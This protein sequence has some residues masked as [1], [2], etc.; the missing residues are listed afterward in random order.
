MRRK[1][2]ISLSILSVGVALLVAA[3]GVG[4]AA[5]S[6]SSLR[7]GTL[8]INQ[9]AGTFDTLDPQLAYVTNDWQV[10]NATQLLLLNYPDRAGQ[11]GERLVPEA[12]KAFPTVSEHGTVYTYHLRSGLRFSDGS[13][14]TAAAFQR[15]FERVLSPKMFAQYGIYDG[16]DRDIVGGQAFAATGKAAGR[17]HPA[18]H[19][20]GIEA[21][22]LTL[23]IHL[24]H[25]MP[26]F[27][28]LLALEWFSATKPDLPYTAKKS[29]ILKYPSAGPYYLASNNL[30]GDTILKRN[31][32]Y[33][34]SRPANPD[35]IVIHNLTDPEGS[36]QEIEQ[37]KVDYDMG[38][39][40][41]D[42]VNA[43]VQK[44]G[45]P[46]S[47]HGQFRIGLE[48][49]CFEWE[50][51][52]DARPPTDNA[53]VRRALN[54]AIGRT[55]IL[56]LVG[57]YSGSS[58]DQILPPGVQG[59]RKLS[60]YGDFPNVSKAEQVGGSALKNAPPLLIYYNGLSPART[61]EAELMQSEFQAIGLKVTMA[62]ET[63]G[64]Y[65]G[66]LETKGTQWNVAHFPGCIDVADPSS[67]FN[68]LLNANSLGF[69]ASWIG[70]NDSSFVSEAEHAAS[71]SGT[72]RARAY[73]AL[74]KQLMTTDAPVI[75]LSIPNVSY[76]V[77]RRV[78][79]IIFDRY[80][81]GPLLNAMSV[82]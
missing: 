45:P 80:F 42:A 9:S 74:D 35:K 38:G 79:N 26:S 50:A 1:Q 48:T 47:Q 17:R 64:D 31:R 77:S 7:G 28:S 61:H 43:L 18:K 71:L 36:V 66:P 15:A 58:T 22:G 63:T 33:H 37:G 2:L 23:T 62:P 70:F 75:P 39:V 12:A 8:R 16:V 11:A 72:A 4:T 25:A 29:G 14:V 3:T 10:L 40:P 5:G 20:T 65:Y 60:L 51:L 19:I 24:T 69:N 52:N 56:K 6:S 57:P 67:Y 76:L 55:L 13:P 41:S 78:S 59:Y 27:E 81:G 44:Y 30:N 46:S 54:Y 32:Y 53:N 68:Y 49:S 82:R 73:A 34:G 21:R